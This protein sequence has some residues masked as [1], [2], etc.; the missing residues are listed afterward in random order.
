LF[1]DLDDGTHQVLIG[2]HPARD[3]VH[4]NAYCMNHFL[5]MN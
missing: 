5:I 2:A 1:D 3:A 4:D